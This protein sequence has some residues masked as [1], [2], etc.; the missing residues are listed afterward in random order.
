MESKNKW[1]ASAG[2]QKKLSQT[3]QVHVWVRIRPQGVNLGGQAK[4][5]NLKFVESDGSG[6]IIVGGQK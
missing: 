6:H 3:E 4:F 5:Q 1:N 2:K